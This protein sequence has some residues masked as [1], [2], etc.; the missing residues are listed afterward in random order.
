MLSNETLKRLQTEQKKLDEF[1]KKGY[2]QR[3]NKENYEKDS[4]LRVKIALLV[5]IGEFANEL[6]TFKHWKKQTEINWSKAKEELI[7]CLHFFLSLINNYQVDFADYQSEKIVP[8]TSCNEL[9]MEFFWTATQLPT[10]LPNLLT[11][12]EEKENKN[13]FYNSWKAFDKVFQKLGMNEEDIE[14]A[15]MVKNKVNWER[16]KSNY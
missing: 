14:N 15:Y 5:E 3:N 8:E 12:P 11:I 2:L 13:I 7:D 16:Q 1:I 6:K 9:L 10:Q 4:Y